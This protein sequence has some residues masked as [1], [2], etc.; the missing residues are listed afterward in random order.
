MCE[1]PG[2]YHI[3]VVIMAYTHNENFVIFK[4]DIELMRGYINNYYAGNGNYWQSNSAIV[5]TELQKSD[6]I[7]IKPANDVRIYGN[8][9]SC[10]TIVKVK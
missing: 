8:N 4:N 9:H 10:L 2:L 5:L 1:V 6:T 7:D 3:S